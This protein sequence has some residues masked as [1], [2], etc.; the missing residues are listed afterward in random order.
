MVSDLI[1]TVGINDNTLD[2]LATLSD[3]G[4]VS[5]VI[6][7]VI[8]LVSLSISLYPS[9]HLSRKFTRIRRQGEGGLTL[10]QCDGLGIRSGS[11]SYEFHCKVHI[12]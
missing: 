3:I 11:R 2:R 7:D 12:M 4:L 8:A 9:S 10:R 5:L 6:L 1:T